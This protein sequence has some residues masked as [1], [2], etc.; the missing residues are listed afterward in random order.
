MSTA[1]PAK[2][3]CVSCPYRQDVP[4]GLWVREEYEKLPDYD[5]PTGNQPPAAFFCHQNDGRLCAG[6]VGCHGTDA[7]GLR[8]LLYTVPRKDADAIINYET[9]VPLFA[10]GTEACV[11]GLE[12]IDDP[13]PAAKLLMMKITEKRERAEA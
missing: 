6:W 9:D 11:H 13:G 1:V 12:E 4:S 2:R 3:P 7:L 10:S 8:I 5:K